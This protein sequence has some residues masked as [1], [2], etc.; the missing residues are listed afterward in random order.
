MLLHQVVQTTEQFHWIMNYSFY[1]FGFFFFFF[2]LL[3]VKILLLELR[4]RHQQQN[5][6]PIR[7]VGCMNQTTSL[8]SIENH[9]LWD[10]IYHR[11]PFHDYFQC[12]AGFF[13]S[14][15]HKNKSMQSTL[16]T[17]VYSCLFCTCPN[18]VVWFCLMNWKR[19]GNWVTEFQIRMS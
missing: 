9:I 10:V 15:F 2:F 8:S 16:L 4:R 7:L 14:F 18:H 5:F 1:S 6:Y 12:L 3:W 11:I 17:N 13:L 19:Y